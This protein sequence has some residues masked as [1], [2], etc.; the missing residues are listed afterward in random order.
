MN[1]KTRLHRTLNGSSNITLETSSLPS[2]TY[3][4][5]LSKGSDKTTRTVLKE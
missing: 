2:G 1:G 3:L 5:V 4:V